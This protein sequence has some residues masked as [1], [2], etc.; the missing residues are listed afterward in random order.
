MLFE[1]TGTDSI[2]LLGE[3]RRGTSAPAKEG[4]QTKDASVHRI[5]KAPA[6]GVLMHCV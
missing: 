1:E 5:C 4:A 3:N 2:D 6:N